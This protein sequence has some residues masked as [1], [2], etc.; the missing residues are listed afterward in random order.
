MSRVT[1][2]SSKLRARRRAR[3]LRFAVLV[4]LFCVFVVA[5]TVALAHA[6]FWRI[7]KVNV[8]GNESIASSTIASFVQEKLKGQWGYVLPKDNILLYPKASLRAELLTHFP[9][10]RS[11][12]LK[13]ENF[14][15]L[16]VEVGERKP[17]ALW[18][19]ERRSAGDACVLLDDAGIAYGGAV[20]FA[21]SAYLHYYGKATEAGP[22]KQY[23]SEDTFRAVDAV[24]L[25]VAADM[26]EDT[27]IYI[28]VDSEQD[29]HLGFKS[30]F[31]VIYPLDESGAAILERLKLAR[32]A[33]PF[34]TRSLSDFQYLDLRFGDKLYYKLKGE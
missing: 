27:L 14:S 24:A 21:G 25:A 20:S 4:F 26:S 19:G 3:A 11:A 28:E 13:A 1:L 15:T 29:V 5:G 30:G 31:V 2:P 12:V 32:S 7:K 9:M 33:E 10:L 22:A 18:C 16:M 8:V 17:H 34:A 6:P 23:L